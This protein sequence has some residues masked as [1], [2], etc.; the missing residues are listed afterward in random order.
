M[1]TLTVPPPAMLKTHRPHVQ[2]QTIIEC[3]IRKLYYGEFV[4]VKNT[5][6]S[7]EQGKV[8]AFI[9]PSGCGKSTVLRSF[10]RLNDMIRGFRLDGSVTLAG[11]D[12]YSSSIDPVCVR[13]HIGMVFQQPTPFAMSIYDNVA[14]G[15]R[16]N[17]DKQNM[18][19]RVEEALRGAAL[20]DEVKDKLKK[21]ALSLS[22]GQQQRLCIARAI[23]TRPQVLLMDEPCSALDPISTRRIEELIAELRDSYT[24]V[25]V[26]HNLHQAMRVADNTAFMYVDRETRS[27]Y[28][29]EYGPTEQ[30]FKQP[31]QEYTRQY[32]C[33]HFG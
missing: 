11:Q 7:I 32:V 26:T 5:R 21:S 16:I 4:A 8:T 30:I 18:E 14:F 27:G 31:K 3:D 6:I 33:G 17:R 15:L 20:W 25:I 23:A 10:N 24:L 13:R 22:G 12:L 1:T 29:V 28:L 19:Q 2:R 9:G